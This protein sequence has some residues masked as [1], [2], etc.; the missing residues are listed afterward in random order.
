MG[1]SSTTSSKSGFKASNS[2]SP[3]QSS[4]SKKRKQPLHQSL[5]SQLTDGA[6]Q[7]NK[8]PRH[9]TARKSTAP[10]VHKQSYEPETSVPVVRSVQIAQ[11]APRNSQS[12]PVKTIVGSTIKS[13]EFGRSPKKRKFR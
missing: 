6:M 7:S 4:L 11:K 13:P 8:K 3:T 5:E 9:P 1:T 2:K 12:N 10:P